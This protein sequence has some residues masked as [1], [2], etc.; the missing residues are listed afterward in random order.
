MSGGGGAA[1]PRVSVWPD[2]AALV[3]AAAGGLAAA[4]R[5][6]LAERAAVTVALS[7]GRTPVPVYERLAAAPG[8]DWERVTLLLADERWV[9]PVDP[10]SNEGMVRQRLLTGLPGPGPRFWPW[11]VRLDAEPAAVAAAFAARLGSLDPRADPGAP[12][13]LDLLT[14]GMGPEGHTASLFPGSPALAATGWTAAPWVP[15]VGA[16]RLTLTPPVLRAARRTILLAAGADKAVALAAVVDGPVE[17][18]RWPAQVAVR[19]RPGCEVWCDAA[20]AAGLVEGRG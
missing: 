7:G 20:A 3:R 15:E 10:Q 19:G 2:A 6:A 4:L 9:A 12:P 11:A 14:L 5:E 17:P 1:R 8:V 13:V 18:E 16:P